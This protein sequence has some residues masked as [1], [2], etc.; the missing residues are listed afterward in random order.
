MHEFL[1]CAAKQIRDPDTY[2]P[3]L[4]IVDVCTSVEG[5][6]VPTFPV[7]SLWQ[8]QSMSPQ[9]TVFVADSCLSAFDV[10]SQECILV[11]PKQGKSVKAVYQSF[12]RILSLE[13]RLGTNFVDGVF[14]GG[15]LTDLL[16]QIEEM[17]RAHV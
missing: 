9:R 8:H 14:G 3:W 6:P 5:L 13:L 15:Y 12:V 16:K 7:S 11:T 10:S 17:G 1:T 2:R 4:Y